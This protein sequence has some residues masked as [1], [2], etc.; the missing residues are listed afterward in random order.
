[1]QNA[2]N[3]YLLSESLFLSKTLFSKESEQSEIYRDDIWEGDMGIYVVAAVS[4][5]CFVRR[6][7]E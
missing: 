5:I 1:M 2:L 7:G 4:L 3:I 6:C